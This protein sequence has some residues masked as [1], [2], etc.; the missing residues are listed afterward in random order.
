M[1]S[2]YLE[3]FPARMFNPVSPIL[4]I[5]SDAKGSFPVSY[6]IS[7]RPISSSL[8]NF[9]PHQIIFQE[10]SR[11]NLDII[12]SSDQSLVGL[13]PYDCCFSLLRQGV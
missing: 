11:L 6:H 10:V 1:L 4:Q 3:C 9:P 13:S 2:R 12:S 8:T 5:F 7:V